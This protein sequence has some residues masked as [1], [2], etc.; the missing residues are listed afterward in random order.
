MESI[1]LCI[2]IISSFEDKS[3]TENP[4]EGSPYSYIRD[5]VPWD[6]PSSEEASG[7]EDGVGDEGGVN[8]SLDEDDEALAYTQER[9]IPR[10]TPMAVEWKEWGT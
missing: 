8:A 7:D 10:L 5:G 2:S 9:L 4:S 1:R 3:T 6:E